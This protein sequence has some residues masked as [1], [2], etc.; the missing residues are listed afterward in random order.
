MHVYH[1]VYRC[2]FNYGF[3]KIIHI[4]PCIFPC[5]KDKKFGAKQKVCLQGWAGR[6]WGDRRGGRGGHGVIGGVG[7]EGVGDRRDG[8]GGRVVQVF[9]EFANYSV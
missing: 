1:N 7:E 5:P 6:V 3:L 2:T 8:R 9:A 4:I